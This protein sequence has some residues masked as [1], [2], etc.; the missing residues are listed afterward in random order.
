MTKD[1]SVKPNLHL[2]WRDKRY[3]RFY[4]VTDFLVNRIQKA[5]LRHSNSQVNINLSCGPNVLDVC[6]PK[7]AEKFTAAHYRTI[8]PLI[9]TFVT[10]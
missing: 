1:I 2:S 9:L 7:G 6:L 5:R 10:L 8:Q 3:Q 4:E